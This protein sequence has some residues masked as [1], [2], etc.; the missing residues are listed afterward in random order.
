MD[1]DYQIFYTINSLAG[2][3]SFLNPLM[4]LLAQDA[5]YLFILGVIFYWFSRTEQNRRMVGE[6]L[7]SVCLGLMVSGILGQLL[8]RDRPFVTHTVFQLIKHPANASFPSDH[9]IAAFAIA[10]SIWIFHR[11]AGIF[12]LILAT[13]IGFSRIWVGVHYPSDV[14]AGVLIGALSSVII[15]LLF[16]RWKLARQGLSGAIGL[17]EKAEQM[18]WVRK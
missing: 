1:T 3:L 6:A 4:S 13:A 10:M 12:W 9:T 8:Y 5:Q 15:H 18:V 2:T 11:K 16:T 17:Y 7:I 14:L